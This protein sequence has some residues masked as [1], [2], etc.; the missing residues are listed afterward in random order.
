MVESSDLTRIV[1]RADVLTMSRLCR[2]FI[3]YL[4]MLHGG[5]SL[6]RETQTGERSDP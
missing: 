5:E 4:Y 3:L 2:G 6:Q 1:C